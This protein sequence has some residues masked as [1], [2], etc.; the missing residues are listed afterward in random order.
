MKL[1]VGDVIKPDEL[2]FVIIRLDLN[3]NNAKCLKTGRIMNLSL[4]GTK[5]LIKTGQWRKLSTLH[6]RLQEVKC[7]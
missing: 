4:E 1:K 5:Q 3:A 6:V 2:P 7:G